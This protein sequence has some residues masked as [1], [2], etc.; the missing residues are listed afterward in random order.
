MLFPPLFLFNFSFGR[1]QTLQLF[2][3]ELAVDI[4]DRSTDSGQFGVDPDRCGTPFRRW[5]IWHAPLRVPAT[6]R[7]MH[8]G[9]WHLTLPKVRVSRNFSAPD[10][11]PPI[12]MILSF[13][14]EAKKI[15]YYELITQPLI[16]NCPVMSRNKCDFCPLV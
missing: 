5:G 12:F 15:H 13:P 8:L 3:G 6:I 7:S 4:P 14:L 11:L 1:L 10:L 16:S 2:L 9:L